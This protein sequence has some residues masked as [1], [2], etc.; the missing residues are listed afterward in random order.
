MRCSKAKL[1]AQSPGRNV[2]NSKRMARD[3]LQCLD[4]M[5]SSGRCRVLWSGHLWECPVGNCC[6]GK[7][8]RP[9]TPSSFGIPSQTAVMSGRRCG[10][11]LEQATNS[12]SKVRAI[13][14]KTFPFPHRPILRRHFESQCKPMQGRQEA[15]LLTVWLAGS[16]SAQSAGTSARCWTWT[17]YVFRTR[18]INILHSGGRGSWLHDAKK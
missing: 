11:L 9:D 6:K 15:T 1:F 12:A 10:F 5:M 16:I 4:A 7:V 14:K 3:P 18:K 17:E 8:I 2:S 13:S